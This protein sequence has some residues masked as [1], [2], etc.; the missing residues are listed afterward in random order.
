VLRKL[1][2]S[3]FVIGLGFVAGFI[4]VFGFS[5]LSGLLPAHITGNLIFLA[6]VLARGHTDFLIYLLALPLFCLGVI[7]SAW[8]IGTIAERGF[9]PLL[10]ALLVEAGLLVAA[11]VLSLALPPSYSANSLTSLAVG[12]P[13]V[14]AMSMQNTLM[15]MVLNNLPPTTVMTG[16]ITQVLGDFTA[17]FCRFSSIRHT[18]QEKVILERQAYRMLLTFLSFLAGALLSAFTNGHFRGGALILPI[19][20]LLALLPYGRKPQEPSASD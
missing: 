11:M 12:T 9:E 5:R 6:L 16:N 17:Y 14:L 2:H 8:F 15:R 13:V 18:Q 10:P 4:D 20:A 1:D 7:L 3:A 19:L